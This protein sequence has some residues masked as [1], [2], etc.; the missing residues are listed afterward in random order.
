MIQRL[1]TFAAGLIGGSIVGLGIALLG[2]PDSGRH[3]RQRLRHDARRRINDSAQA[4]EERRAALRQE[5]QARILPPE[6]RR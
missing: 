5:F 3:L 4:A 6:D 2:A 1:S